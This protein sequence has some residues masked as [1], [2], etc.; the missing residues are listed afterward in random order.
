MYY[1]DAVRI[2]KTN[3]FMNLVQGSK[4][5][6]ENVKEFD[7]LANSLLNGYRQKWPKGNDS[8]EDLTLG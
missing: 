3:E 1:C 7:G 6:M 4:T 8:I 2:M 5:V